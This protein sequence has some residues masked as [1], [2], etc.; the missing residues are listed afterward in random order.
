MSPWPVSLER[1]L[2]DSLDRNSVIN[3]VIRPILSCQLCCQSD[4]AG[5]F[6][7]LS[8]CHWHFRHFSLQWNTALETDS[9]WHWSNKGGSLHFSCM[10]PN[11][12]NFCCQSPVKSCKKRSLWMY[13]PDLLCPTR[14]I[15]CSDAYW[16]IRSLSHNRSLI[17]VGNLSLTKCVK[18]DKAKLALSLCCQLCCQLW[19]GN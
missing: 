8:L 3:A 7:T 14:W 13:L 16:S 5:L 9:A 12:T 6:V 2:D 15:L 10:T 4:K 11:L 17:S 19:H 18:G 1:T